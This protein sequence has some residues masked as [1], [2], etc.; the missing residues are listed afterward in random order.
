MALSKEQYTKSESLTK[1]IILVRLL[2]LYAEKG[3]NYF[4]SSLR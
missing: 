3:I 4:N 1:N 2:F